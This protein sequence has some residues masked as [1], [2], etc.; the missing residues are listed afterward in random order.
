MSHI[1]KYNN[2]N[3]DRIPALIAHEITRCYSLLNEENYF[4]V[5]YQIKD[6]Y[7][8]LIKTF[9]LVSI[10]LLEE[11]YERLHSITEEEWL[12][13]YFD[14]FE[15][16]EQKSSLVKKSNLK[17]FKIVCN[18][19]K[20]KDTSANIKTEKKLDNLSIDY[21]LDYLSYKGVIKK[22]IG[23]SLTLGVW[24]EIL[25]NLKGITGLDQ[26]MREVCTSIYKSIC[27][28]GDKRFKLVKWR[29]SEIGHGALS[30]NIDS[31]KIY[32]IEKQMNIIVNIIYTHLDFFYSMDFSLITDCNSLIKFNGIDCLSSLNYDDSILKLSLKGRNNDLNVDPLI[33]I[34]NNGI[35]LFDSFVPYRIDAFSIDYPNGIRDKCHGKLLEWLYKKRSQLNIPKMGECNSIYETI[36]S[37]DFTRQIAN[38][39]NAKD[40]VKPEYLINKIE[41][42]IESEKSG[43]LLLSLDRGMG[44]TYF[45]KA[46]NQ[47]DNTKDIFDQVDTDWIIRTIHLNTYTM[48][49]AFLFQREVQ[50]SI[51]TDSYTVGFNFNFSEDA[52]DYDKQKAFANYLNKIRK[53]EYY[54][55]DQK[56]ILVIDGLD[57]LPVNETNSILSLIPHSSLLDEGV[58]IILTARTRSEKEKEFTLPQG[59]NDIFGEIDNLVTRAGIYRETF[60]TSY[61]GYQ[62]FIHEYLK[63]KG[64]KLS[65]QQKSELMNDPERI[66]MVY[67]GIMTK[68]YNYN[69][70]LTIFSSDDIILTYLN[71]ISIRIENRKL[72]TNADLSELKS[73]YM[74]IM[75]DVLTVLT[76]YNEPLNLYQIKYLI[77][78][79]TNDYELIGIL[80]DIKGLIS[81]TRAKNRHQLYALSH[82]DIRK[83]CE[84]VLINQVNELKKDHKYLIDNMKYEE[85]RESLKITLDLKER[86]K[87]STKVN[88]YKI[89]DSV[90]GIYTLISN[91]HIYY[92][93]MRLLTDFKLLMLINT[94]ATEIKSIS[95]TVKKIPM[96]ILI[97]RK[98]YSYIDD[99]I[100][101]NNSHSGKDKLEYYDIYSN[102]AWYLCETFIPTNIK[103]S[104]KIFNK[105]FKIMENDHEVS[106]L[107]FSHVLNR[108]G[109][110]CRR[111]GE[112]TEALE[113]YTKAY[114]LIKDISGVQ[115]IDTYK[116]KI[117]ANF[118]ID[119]R[120]LFFKGFN[121]KDINYIPDNTILIDAIEK[122]TT[123][124]SVKTEIIEAYRVN[125]NIESV[126]FTFHSR[127]LHR[128]FLGIF[129]QFKSINITHK[130]PNYKDVIL[131]LEFFNEDI[132]KD[133]FLILNDAVN[134]YKQSLEYFEESIELNP[135]LYKHQINGFCHTHI[136]DCLWLLRET[137]EAA[138]QYQKAI[139]IFKEYL[140]AENANVYK[141]YI[142][143]LF[144]LITLFSSEDKPENNIK[145]YIMDL[146]NLLT[147]ITKYYKFLP[148]RP[149]YYKK[150]LEFFPA[151]N[152]FKEFYRQR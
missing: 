23:T 15:K 70:D 136:G 31:D 75:I 21:L 129:T 30:L 134:D 46:L 55:E 86:D 138:I 51:F 125:E 61:D 92:S 50:N 52:S 26:E 149:I 132:D 102:Y 10:A 90:I 71:I 126:G 123:A 107:Q 143:T 72:N 109:L 33:K 4:L 140:D 112:H 111:L 151:N 60:H 56:F 127:G 97:I 59:Y 80:N 87:N 78:E 103:I 7:E 128:Y 135:N 141:L 32:E 66:K 122:S 148:I 118:A 1:D 84:I 18:I 9:C 17:K 34:Y 94:L 67:I 29:N 137:S 106:L 44:K 47:N 124:V 65:K 77:K 76:M 152:K 20:N 39:S 25:C 37:I 49:E 19:T 6:M 88:V 101:C 48:F 13:R 3:W 53:R 98:L 115:D 85:I 12:K 147:T 43:I 130:E 99:Y 38:L 14:E 82:I 11:K 58:Y 74:K 96:L 116:P 28:E 121:N 150:I 79:H 83:N 40:F 81:V 64:I 36:F 105:L 8:V 113:Y 142:Y 62:N 104:Q 100:S 114:D 68:C 73:R 42:F 93:K 89:V 5:I 35:F 63:Q 120:A 131:T 95:S 41:T 54:E 27:D 24:Q 91:V 2:I 57:E 144:N 69:N 145:E 146:D 119:K 22:L 133:S 139:D 117:F 45:S 110:T 108:L 16:I